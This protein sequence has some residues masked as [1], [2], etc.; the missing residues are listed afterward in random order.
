MEKVE[1]KAKAFKP[2]APVEKI[3][4][5]PGASK[6]VCSLEDEGCACVSMNKEYGLG[7]EG[8]L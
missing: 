6:C 3:L 7:G 2:R 1:K 8:C 4:R 5:R